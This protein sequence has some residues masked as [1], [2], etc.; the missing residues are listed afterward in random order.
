MT[1]IDWSRARGALPQTEVASG[2]DEISIIS[3]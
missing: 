1:G 3:N 2:R